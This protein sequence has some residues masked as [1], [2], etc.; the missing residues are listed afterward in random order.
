M[1]VEQ[2]TYKYLCTLE[3]DNVKHAEMKDKI[4]KNTS[5][6]ENCLKPNYIA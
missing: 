5:E 3:A 6:L 1:L 4:K 2:E